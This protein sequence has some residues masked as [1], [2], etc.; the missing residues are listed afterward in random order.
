MEAIQCINVTVSLSNNLKL[1]KMKEPKDKAAELVEKFKIEGYFDYAEH[2]QTNIQS[3][4]VKSNAIHFAKIA[5]DEIIYAVK[6]QT[7]LCTNS[8]TNLDT[9]YW[10]QVRLELDKLKNQNHE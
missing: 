9:K 2:K 5:V 1:R 6:V 3:D 10:Q 7:L 8:L 4:I